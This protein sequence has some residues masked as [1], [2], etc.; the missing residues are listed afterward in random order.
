ML[1]AFSVKYISKIIESVFINHKMISYKKERFQQSD[2]NLF[3]SLKK[4]IRTHS[5]FKIAHV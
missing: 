3:Y 1:V 5:F 2:R 4:D